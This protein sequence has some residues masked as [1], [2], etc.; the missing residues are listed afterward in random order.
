[1]ISGAIWSFLE[2]DVEGRFMEKG[3]W[4]SEPH[5]LSEAVCVCGG[6]QNVLELVK[7]MEHLPYQERP[8]SLGLFRK[9][10]QGIEVGV[11]EMMLGA[12]EKWREG[13]VV[14]HLFLQHWNQGV[15]NETAGMPPYPLI[16]HPRITQVLGR[17]LKR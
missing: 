14:P 12:A 13:S 3:G 17:L 7:G 6:E 15:S 10:R 5:A 16:R 1:M 4:G 11:Y 2:W 8:Q 9:C